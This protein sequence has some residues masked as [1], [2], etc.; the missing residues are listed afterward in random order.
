[1]V[2]PLRQQN[3]QN[4]TAT[5][6]A[7]EKENLPLE[8]VGGVLMRAGRTTRPPTRADAADDA[9]LARVLSARTTGAAASK[10]TKRRTVTVEVEE[11]ASSGSEDE[12]MTGKKT[13]R[14]FCPAM[15]RDSIV[16]MME[17]HYCAHPLLPGYAPPNSD[18][19]KRWAVS[20][21]YKFCVEHGLREVWVYLWENWYRRS[22]WEL[23]ARSANPEIPVLKTTMILE[24]Q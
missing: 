6:P 21:M 9:S 20:Q 3:I 8:A 4:A 13:R 18:G 12:E 14:T 2:F 10:V 22:R 24:S 15:Y 7:G 1:M 16:N 17:K 11:A 5:P 23:W 19:I